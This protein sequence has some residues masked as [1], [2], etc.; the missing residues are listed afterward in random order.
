MQSS[1]A[2]HFKTH[3][4]HPQD[5]HLLVSSI[6]VPAQIKTPFVVEER[7]TRVP[8]DLGVRVWKIL[9]RKWELL[10]F[11]PHALEVG[12]IDTQE[13]IAG[14]PC[15]S[16]NDHGVGVVDVE[17]VLDPPRDVK[18]GRGDARLQTEQHPGTPHHNAVIVTVLGLAENV[19]DEAFA[20]IGKKT[21]GIGYGNVEVAKKEC[22]PA[23]HDGEGGDNIFDILLVFLGGCSWGR[24]GRRRSTNGDRH[25][26]CDYSFLLREILKREKAV[27]IL[28]VRR[29]RFTSEETY[30]I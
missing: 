28:F 19:K 2:L 12:A 7:A 3:K 11:G 17:L 4:S 30:L 1:Q 18:E 8:D 25:L 27:S 9:E 10:T 16:N 22:G 23:L 21:R 15:C 14:P 20:P 6:E 13:E 26:F 24:N 29:E 5:W